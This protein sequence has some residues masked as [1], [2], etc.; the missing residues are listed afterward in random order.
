[1]N[2]GDLI[3]DRDQRDEI[4]R[5]VK[6]IERQVGTVVEKSNW[7]ALYVVGMNLTIIRANLTN[8]PKTSPN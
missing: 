8:M 1:M 3:L 5:A 7:Q 2:D 6:A 4:L